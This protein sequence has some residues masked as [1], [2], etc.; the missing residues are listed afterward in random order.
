M[1]DPGHLDDLL[2]ALLDGELGPAEESAATAHLTGCPA[3]TAELEAIGTVRRAVRSLPAVDPPFGFYERMLL[4]GAGGGSFGAPP[5]WWRDRRKAV[6]AA[7]VGS[8]AVSVGFL[9]VSSPTP[10]PVRPSVASLIEAHATSASVTGDVLST[11]TPAGVPVSF[12]P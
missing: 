8:A 6:A 9:G 4:P 7:L 5:P 2:S 12:G 1:T 10:Q 3:C 11:L